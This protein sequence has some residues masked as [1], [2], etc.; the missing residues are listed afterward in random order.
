MNLSA[1]GWIPKFLTIVDKQ[2]IKENINDIFYYYKKLKTTG[3]L[4]GTST[5]ALT[6]K[7]LLSKLN[8]TRDEYTK[9]NLF[10][11]L[12]LYFLQINPMQILTMQL[13]VLL[14]STKY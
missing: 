6:S 7:P 9:I 14:H 12:I 8:I 5:E 2:H 10:Q 4:Y 1:S 11:S 13:L 3:F